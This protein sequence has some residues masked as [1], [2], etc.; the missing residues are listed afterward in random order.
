MK[1]QLLTLAIATAM[2]AP[3]ALH[4]LPTPPP[5]PPHDAF[6]PDVS[7]LEKDLKLDDMQVESIKQ[8]NGKYKV[9]YQGYRDQIKPIEKEIQDLK[10]VSAT[11]DYDK[12]R[13]AFNRLNPIHTEIKLTQIKHR[14]EIRS[15]L[16][17]Q[18]RDEQDRL[19]KEKMDK[20][21]ERREQNHHE[22]DRP[23]S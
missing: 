1:K 19:R 21:K 9:I 2:M 16:T 13:D 11:P 5:P 10:E 22:E 14:Q 3:G 20:I 6:A 18:Q 12:L 8:I 15:V 7:K 4:A 23:S 17:P